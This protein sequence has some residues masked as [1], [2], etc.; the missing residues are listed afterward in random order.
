MGFLKLGA[1]LISPSPM[2]IP[3]VPKPR[4][5]GHARAWEAL[6]IASRTG[7]LRLVEDVAL[8]TSSGIFLSQSWPI[9]VRPETNKVKFEAEDG[10][11]D[12]EGAQGQGQQKVDSVALGPMEGSRAMHIC[13]SL[14]KHERNP[15]ARAYAKLQ[16]GIDELSRHPRLAETAASGGVGVG[17]PATHSNRTAHS[18]RTPAHGYDAGRS[19]GGTPL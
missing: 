7:A 10:N 11:S 1:E 9:Q 17:G 13:E 12:E 2:M 6:R 8:A 18:N 14:P 16:T 15:L 5:I 4:V 3:Q 19:I